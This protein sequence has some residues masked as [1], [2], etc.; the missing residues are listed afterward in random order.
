MSG[1]DTTHEEGIRREQ[2]ATYAEL[3][4]LEPGLRE[5]EARIAAVEDPGGP[6]FCSNFV[7]LPLNADLKDLVGAARR[8]PVRDDP[9]TERLLRSSHCY[10][11]AYLALSKLLPP[12]RNCGC[13]RFAPYE[14]AQVEDAER[15]RTESS[16]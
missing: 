10:E 13:R 7:W 2:A 14:K 6:W 16:T 11:T 5:L 4:E 15:L 8:G 9:E 3:C 12:C 1:N